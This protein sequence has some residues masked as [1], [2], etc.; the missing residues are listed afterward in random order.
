MIGPKAPSPHF[1]VTKLSVEGDM[2]AQA[3][4]PFTDLNGQ[5]QMIFQGP[6]KPGL[7]LSL[8]AQFALESLRLQKE[9][10]DVLRQLQETREK[11]AERIFLLLVTRPHIPKAW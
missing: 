2:G 6:L 4:P 5:D 1:S 11:S 3:E 9:A 10:D 7:F 8:H